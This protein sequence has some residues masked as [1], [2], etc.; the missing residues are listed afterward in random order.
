MSNLH[1]VLLNFR[2]PLLHEWYNEPKRRNSIRIRRKVLPFLTCSL[3]E[4]W[5]K[6]SGSE[7]SSLSRIRLQISTAYL[8]RSSITKLEK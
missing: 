5:V 6:G 3:I 1:K 8:F 4:L 2:Y 7:P